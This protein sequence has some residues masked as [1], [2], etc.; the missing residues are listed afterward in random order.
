MINTFLSLVGH[1]AAV[2][3]RAGIV[4]ILVACVPGLAVAGAQNIPCSRPFIFQGA[5]VNVV[6][7]PYTS[8]PGLATAGGIGDS[9]SGLLQLEVLRAI[10]KFGSV[11]AVQMVGSAADCDPDLVVAKL[12]G[13]TPGAAATAA[14]SSFKPSAGCCDRELTRPS[15]SS[16]QAGRSRHK[17]P[18]R[19]SHARRAK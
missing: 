12:L 5:A 7:L 9:L 15:S 14:T 13:R 8:A 10:A 1:N 19:R 11:G 17:S 16:P 4:A 2:S 3:V 18:R 6:V